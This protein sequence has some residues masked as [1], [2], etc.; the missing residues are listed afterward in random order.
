MLLHELVTTSQTVA[1]TR[2]RT[3][4]TEALAAA[5]ATLSDEELPAGL[6]FLAGHPRQDRLGT[7]WATVAGTDAAAADTPV[8]TVLEVDAALDRLASLEGEGSQG[9]REQELAALFG[10]ATAAEQE[11]LR[12]ML[13]RELRQGASDSLV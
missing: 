11:W 7:G 2:S 10:R 8:L 12:G 3:A 6:A 5:V 13:L 4:K 1:A 9:E